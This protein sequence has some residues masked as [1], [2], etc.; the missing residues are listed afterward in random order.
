MASIVVA[1]CNPSVIFAKRALKDT[2]R[3]SRSAFY[4]SLSTV[5]VVS[6]I[7]RNRHTKVGD[8]VG[9]IFLLVPGHFNATCFDL[10]YEC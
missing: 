9:L 1:D 3:P 2:D 5:C 8:I 7:L 10:V 4:V 6:E